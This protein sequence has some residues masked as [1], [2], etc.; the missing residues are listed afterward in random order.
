MAT[1]FL[2]PFHFH[3]QN[4]FLYIYC[5]EHPK[6][7]VPTLVIDDN[8]EIPLYKFD[9]LD[10]DLLNTRINIHNQLTGISKHLY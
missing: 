7:E 6:G 10:Y 3:F 8:P 1:L 9:F 5:A 2:N 4:I